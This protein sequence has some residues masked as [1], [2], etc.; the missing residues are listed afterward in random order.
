VKI[1][2]CMK[3]VPSS[4]ARIALAPD[5]VSINTAD[6]E[7]AINPYDE[8]AVEE[9][10]QIVEARGEGEVIIL[11]IG[12]DKAIES[13]RKCLAMGA[14]RGILVKDEAY[15][16][17]D[18]LGNARIMADIIKGI[19]PDLVLTGKLSIDIENDGTGVALAEYLGWPHV[20]FV[21]KLEWTDNNTA[22][23]IRNIEGGAEV[24]EVGMPAV[25][26]A[27]K[28]LNEPRYPK[29]KGVMQAKRKPLDE[30][31]PSMAA[32]E[33][34]AAAAKVTVV[35]LSPPPDRAG[36]QKFEGEVSEIVPK[37]VEL[38]KSEAKVL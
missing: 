6:V 17:G 36:G 29:L 33:V 1:V 13:I 4:E 20:T 19:A 8:Y 37:V 28:G 5:G 10:L 34:G 22:K 26:T 7:M 24:V 14:T 23:A 27:E 3:Q 25:M 35:S 30:V 32:S 11:T 2:V 16:G 12:P 15:L 31:T 21:H 38:L 9:A 18:C